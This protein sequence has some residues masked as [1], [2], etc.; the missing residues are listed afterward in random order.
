MINRPQKPFHEIISNIRVSFLILLALFISGTTGYYILG[1]GQWSWIDCAYMTFITLSTIGYSEVFDLSQRPEVRVFTMFLITFGLGI[2][3][4]YL[5]QLVSYF[6]EGDL[7]LIFWKKKMEKD[8]KKLRN[9]VIVCGAGKTGSHT[10]RQ[11]IASGKQ[12]VI[13]E[14]REQIINYLREE[15]MI[16]IPIILGDATDDDV[17]IKAGILNAY[18][19]ISSLPEDKDNIY[20]IIS[21]KS[22]NPNLKIVSKSVD[23]KAVR[24]FYSV[25]ANHVVSS[26]E[27]GGIRMAAQ[28]I[29]PVAVNFIEQ[30]VRRDDHKHHIDALMIPKDSIYVGITLSEANLRKHTNVLILAFREREDPTYQFSPSFDTILKADMEIIVLA[31]PQDFITLRALLNKRV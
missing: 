2:F 25:G 20:V 4:Y 15:L 17:L 16:E 29:S 11:M 26:T 31:S 18:G 1:Y 5:S 23:H 13:I 30:L 22:L 27:I 14:N 24:K 21:A 7:H 19:L 28:M 8:A 10:V 9:H 3:A 6:V 12:V